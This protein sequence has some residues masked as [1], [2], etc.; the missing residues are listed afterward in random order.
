MIAELYI[1]TKGRRVGEIHTMFKDEYGELWRP[2]MDGKT[3]RL[4]YCK[5]IDLG[6][7]WQPYA[8]FEREK[9][10]ELNQLNDDEWIKLERKGYYLGVWLRKLS[11]SGNGFTGHTYHSG[12]LIAYS[13]KDYLADSESSRLLK[14]A[15]FLKAV[16]EKEGVPWLPSGGEESDR[17]HL[18]KTIEQNDKYMV[19]L[20]AKC[21]IAFVI[22]SSLFIAIS[23]CQPPHFL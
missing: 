19:A 17:N 20:A 3:C 23:S 1:C 6:C 11:G 10:K 22:L 13:L 12:D 2:Y 7:I 14:R 4:S 15:E 5:N 21:T 9:L 8:D 18:L 16:C